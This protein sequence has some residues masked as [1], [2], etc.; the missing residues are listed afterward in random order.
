MGAADIN[1]ANTPETLDIKICSRLSATDAWTLISVVVDEKEANTGDKENVT[2]APAKIAPGTETAR[3]LMSG[4]L[5]KE[6]RPFVLKKGDMNTTGVSCEH[7]I[8]KPANVTKIMELAGS[9]ALGVKVKTILPV[10]S[11]IVC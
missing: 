8:P 5:M 2:L 11:T 4:S 6:A 10:P 1:A 9:D 7:V 3:T